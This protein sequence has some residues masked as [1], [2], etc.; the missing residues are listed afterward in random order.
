MEQDLMKFDAFDKAEGTSPKCDIPRSDQQRLVEQHENNFDNLYKKYRLIL[1]ARSPKAAAS[2]LKIAINK[3]RK[4]ILFDVI[5]FNFLNYEDVLLL[6]SLYEDSDK[7]ISDRL[8]KEV[9]LA[10]LTQMTLA[11]KAQC[12]YAA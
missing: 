4:T 6:R 9:S 10:Y 12:Q 7:L 3:L 1:E 5:N 11:T 2:S 8:N